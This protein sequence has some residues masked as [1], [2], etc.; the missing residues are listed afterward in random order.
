MRVAA[1]ILT[2]SAAF[3]SAN[4]TL[5]ARQ[6]LPSCATTCITGASLGSCSA[7][8]DSCLCNDQAF[9]SSTTSC[10]ES[11]CTGNDLVEAEQYAQ[12]IC[13]A[14]GVTLS[15]TAPASTATTPS[16]TSTTTTTGTSTAATSTPSHTNGASLSYGIN[17]FA[18]A[19]AAVAF[20][21]AL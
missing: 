14:V 12:A 6:T 16:S 20:G 5:F 7:T 8:D 3:S 13:L 15:V 4:A 9:I 1:A 19:A 17:L 11:S 21:A 18:G 10:I 2:L